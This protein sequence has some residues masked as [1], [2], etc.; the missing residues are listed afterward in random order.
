M[1][2]CYKLHIIKYVYL[3][4]LLIASQIR[5]PLA[6]ETCQTESKCVIAERMIKIA[7]I[8]IMLKFIKGSVF[9]DYQFK[10]VVEKIVSL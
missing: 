9:I 10:I 5:Y 3:C 2:K 7:S 6:N 1:Q 8:G 4:N